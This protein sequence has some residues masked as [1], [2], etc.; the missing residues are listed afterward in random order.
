MT[1][2]MWAYRLNGPMSF[3]RLDVDAPTENDLPDDQVIMRFLSGGICGSDIPRCWNGQPSDDP[4][5]IGRSLHEIVG[6][7]I[8]TSSD[9]PVGSRVVGWVSHQHGLRELIVSKANELIPAPDDLSPAHAVALQPLAC[10]LA[11]LERVPGIAGARAAVIG[12]GPIGLW[13][14]HALKDKGA[15]HVTGVD[16]IDRSDVATTFGID[17]VV[18]STS[19]AWAQSTSD[20]FDVVIEAV[21]HQV[22]TLDDAITVID[23]HGTIVYFGIP[24]EAVYPLRIDPLME[25]NVA[26]RFGRTPKDGRREA[27]DK[28]VVYAQRYPGIMADYVTHVLPVD[29][30]EEAFRVAARPAA[31][32]LKVVLNATS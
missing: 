5:Q 16:V 3:E 7:V 2:M 32:R 30:T 29:R 10:I 11:A 25:R 21:G 20:R 14:S 23:H 22:G 31:G 28:A 6:E 27:L 4:D 24:D 1:T 26:L 19:R 15:A 18:T 9:L 13:F 8:A 17:Q 12:L